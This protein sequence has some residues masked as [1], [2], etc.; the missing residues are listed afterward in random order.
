MKKLNSRPVAPNDPILISVAKEIPVEQISSEETKEIVE[1]MLDAAFGRRQNREKPTLVGLAAP[2]IGISKR[3]ILV[4]VGADG[5]G[6]LSDL[7]I[8]INPQITWSSSETNEW[9]EGCWSTDRVCGIVSRPNE[10]KIKAIDQN[11]K[12]VEESYTGYVARIFQHEI[13]HL[14]GKVFVDIITNDENLHWVEE[15][16]FPEY[17]NNE[18][19]RKWP[20]KCSRERWNEIKNA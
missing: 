12:Q 16:E 1:T 19:W 9:Y 5:K 14:N 3:I 2:Q 7:R 18:A 20:K 11:G 10:I 15:D 13:D 8:F 4:D 17:R 6:G